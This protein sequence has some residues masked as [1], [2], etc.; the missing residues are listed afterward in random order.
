MGSIVGQKILFVLAAGN[1]SD[2]ASFAVSFSKWQEQLGKTAIP[3]AARRLA[4]HRA[5]TAWRR[6]SER[7]FRLTIRPNS[8][9]FTKAQS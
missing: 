1:G 7:R 3:G 4:K 5:H 2:W 8:P 9:R 6:I